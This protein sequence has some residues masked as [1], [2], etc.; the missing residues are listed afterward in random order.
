MKNFY[1]IMAAGLIGMASNAQSLYMQSSLASFLTQNPKQ[2]IEHNVLQDL[3]R[4]TDVINLDSAI[5]EPPMSKLDNQMREFPL[6]DERR[7]NCYYKEPSELDSP[8][9]T[10][11]ADKLP[12]DRWTYIQVDDSRGKWGDFAQPDW[13][14]YFGL[15]ASDINGDNYLDIISGRYFYLNPGGDMSGSWTRTDLGSN[16]DALLFVDIDYDNFAD[17]IA[18]A[19]PDIYWFE[20]EDMQGTSWKGKKIGEV[21]P[22]SHVNGQGFTLAQIVSGGMPE[23]VLSTGNGIYYLEIPSKPLSGN[24]PVTLAAEEASEQGLAVGDIDGDG[25]NDIV[26]PYGDRK[27]PRMIGWWKNPGHQSGPWKLKEV[28]KT[29]NYSADRVAVADVN[30]DGHAEILITEESWQ[31]Q[32]PV[33]QLFCFNQGGSQGKS[34]WERRSIL[35]A[36]SMNSLDIADIDH[37][38]DIDLVTCEHK[39][40]DKRLFVLENDGQ[41][42]FTV[43]EI[44]RGKESHL[45][46]LLFDMDSD[47]DLDIISIAWD[48]YRFLHLWRN[49]ALKSK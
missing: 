37:D 33:A 35:K 26:A 28:G 25:L 5:S 38:G 46:T 18:T 2:S 20:A 8:K 9:L 31:T 48:N 12:L 1:L 16:V 44:D 42:Q 32:E 17:C 10:I 19:L 7:T 24:W 41:G 6:R 45:G 4:D 11:P 30:G 23:I 36:C 21:P 22:T 49:D 39:G 15:S 43:H 29:E 3:N 34:S 47:G 14:K 27:D 40:K 13:L